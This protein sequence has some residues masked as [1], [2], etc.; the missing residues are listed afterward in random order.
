MFRIPSFRLFCLA[1]ILAGLALPAW[2]QEEAPAAE[3]QNRPVRLM[4]RLGP[5]DM[6][7]PVTSIEWGVPDRWSITSRYVH[8]FDKTRNTFTISLSPGTDGGRFGMGYQH[9]FFPKGRTDPKS[10][11]RP[12]PCCCAP[13]EIPSKP[14]R[15]APSPGRR[16]AAPCSSSAM[17]GWAGTGRSLRKQDAPMRSGACT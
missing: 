8:I 2:S 15:T 4:W 11:P 12:A 1:G 14:G 6:L 9:I 10:S 16:S 3:Q 17:S 7:L 13:G 5:K